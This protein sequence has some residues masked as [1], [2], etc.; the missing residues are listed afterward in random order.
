MTF[1]KYNFLRKKYTFRPIKH[2]PIDWG[3]IV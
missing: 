3:S 1:A 2:A